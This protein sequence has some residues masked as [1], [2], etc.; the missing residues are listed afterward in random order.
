VFDV[1]SIKISVLTTS[2]A[3]F[4]NLSPELKKY[5]GIPTISFLFIV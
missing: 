5:N 3:S 2:R 4:A 1:L